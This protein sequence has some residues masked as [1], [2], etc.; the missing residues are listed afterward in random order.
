MNKLKTMII[1]ILWYL[2]A[3]LEFV[4]IPMYAAALKNVA[5]TY[6]WFEML[7][8]YEHI[9]ILYG[10]VALVTMAVFAILVLIMKKQKRVSEMV[11]ALICF[12]VQAAGI[13][14][15]LVVQINRGIN[16]LA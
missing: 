4:S 13:I 8:N 1:S 7:R 14:T 3:I 6:S 12:L 9:K 5:I 10:I 2:G 15:M 11:I 16:I